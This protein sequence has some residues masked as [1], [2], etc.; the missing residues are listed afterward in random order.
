MSTYIEIAAL[1]L[2]GFVVLI[3]IAAFVF[4][5][6]RRKHKG[7]SR[8][9]FIRAFSR[10]GIPREILDAVYTVAARG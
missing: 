4:D 1:V 7:V 5:L 2:V 8:E 3:A 9:E 6:R 10:D